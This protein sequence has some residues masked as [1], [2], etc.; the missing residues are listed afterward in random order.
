[1]ASRSV[2]YSQFKRCIW[3]L[4]VSTFGVIAFLM[5]FKHLR[6]ELPL[7]RSALGVSSIGGVLM[8][9]VWF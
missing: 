7:R 4:S 9:W 1:M 2:W 5:W 8:S 6:T 3:V